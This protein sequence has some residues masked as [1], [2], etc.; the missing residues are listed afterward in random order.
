MRRSRKITAGVLAF[1]L[2]GSGPAFADTGTKVGQGIC[3][4]DETA[5][6]AEQCGRPE[7]PSSELENQGGRVLFIGLGDSN[8]GGTAAAVAV[9]R[10][11]N[12]VARV[13]AAVGD[14]GHVLSLYIEDYTADDAVSNLVH[15]IN[16]ATGCLLT[17]GPTGTC[18]GTPDASRSDFGGS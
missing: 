3:K 16:R 11:D 8:D 18:R 14:Q 15:S 4:G 10:E 6:E 7:D 1:G 12:G 2:L 13:G 5:R 17:H 9:G